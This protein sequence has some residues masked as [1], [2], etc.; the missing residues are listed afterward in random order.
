MLSTSSKT[1]TRPPSSLS[2]ALSRPQSPSRQQRRGFRSKILTSCKKKKRSF[3]SLCKLFIFCSIATQRYVG[4]SDFDRTAIITDVEDVL[5]QL[6]L[7]F[8]ERKKVQSITPDEL[9]REHQNYIP[10]L[11]DDA[12]EWLFRLVMLF[13]NALPVSLKKIVVSWDYKLPRLS[14]L[15]T[16]ASQQH[17]LEVLREATASAK[18]D[19][20]E[21]RQRV[22]TMVSSLS[23]R[24][25]LVITLTF[26]L[27]TT[28]PQFP[29]LYYTTG[30]VR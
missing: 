4:T 24:R 13:L 15:N 22:E 10:L 2:S 19:Y 25:A 23:P 11:P 9:Y 3:V 30:L 17:E 29:H 27:L 20:D 1:V 6:K 12:Q 18:L 26:S 21:E 16:A 8:K 14:D 7:E 5:S 28:H